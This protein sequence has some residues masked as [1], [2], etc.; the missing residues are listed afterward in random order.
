MIPFWKSHCALQEMTGHLNSTVEAVFSEFLY[1]CKVFVKY[2]LHQNSCVDFY[3]Y[4]DVGDTIPVCSFS[5]SYIIKLR[6][7][8]DD[9]YCRDLK[10]TGE[11]VQRKAK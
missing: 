10:L 9:T 6:M 2:I 7:Y 8:W 1:I 11:K 5:Y 4:Q 3:R